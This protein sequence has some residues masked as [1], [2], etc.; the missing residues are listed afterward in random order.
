M[1]IPL[2]LALAMW[3]LSD[4]SEP[5]ADA[6]PRLETSAADLPGYRIGPEDVLQVSVWGNEA[7]SRTAPVRPDG[8]ISLPLLNDVQAAGLTPMELRDELSRRLAEYI[9]H[10]E[11]AV[12][13]TEVKSFKVSVIGAV[14]KPG[15]YELK[16]RATVIDVLAL[17]EGFTEFAAR[18]R[19]VVMRSDGSRVERLPFDY[20]KVASGSSGQAN[21]YVRAGDIVLVP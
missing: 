16:S 11:V 3:T 13:V 15:R 5:A 8:R 10:P 18:S 17:A 21:F 14:V 9:P 4:G 7:V 6:R 12:S 19:V 1:M 20:D 2:V